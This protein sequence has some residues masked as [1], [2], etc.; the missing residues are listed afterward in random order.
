MDFYFQLNKRILRSSP[1]KSM[2]KTLLLNY[3]IINNLFKLHCILRYKL[4]DKKSFVLSGLR[5]LFFKRTPLK[6]L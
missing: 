4:L 3:V 2:V 1:V 5:K 6:K